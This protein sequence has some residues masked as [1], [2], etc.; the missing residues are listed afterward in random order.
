MANR[1]MFSMDVVDTDKFLDMPSST[2]ALYFHLG[3]RA[4]DDGFVSSPKR[5]TKT[6][7]CGDDD[8]KLLLAKGYLIPFESG[9]VVISDWNVNNWI[10]PD[11]KH[12]TR[13]EQEKRTLSINNY[14]YVLTD[15][16]T[17]ICQSAGNQVTTKCHTED[18]LG[19]DSIGKDRLGKVSIDYQQIADM[20][21]NTCVSFPRLS[22]LSESRKKAIK[23]RLQT[24]SVED[25][26]RMFEMAEGSSFLKGANNRNW[27]AT[28][29]WMVKDANMAK[30][31]DGN[32]QDRQS[33]PQIPEK[34]PE[35]IERE[36]REEQEA[37]DRIER[38]EK[39]EYVYDPEHPFQ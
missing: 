11:R 29:D 7:N 23:A 20:Y 30:I 10:R 38:A 33:E 35:E 39:R 34:T 8:L 12:N 3:M 14:V 26:Q 37:L 2:Q 9:V 31:L 24:Y 13:F 28:F 21:N 18:R 16:V 27:S 25:F 4:D 15:S 19:K 36:K 22:K 32:Y 1:R 17:T 5:I 6:V